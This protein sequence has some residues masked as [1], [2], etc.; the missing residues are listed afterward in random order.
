MPSS[1]TMNTSGMGLGTII[2]NYGVTT[3]LSTFKAASILSGGFTLSMQFAG[4]SGFEV[5]VFSLQTGFNITVTLVK[6]Y[7]IFN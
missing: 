2:V 7:K 4:T 5:D 1:A 6:W 3:L